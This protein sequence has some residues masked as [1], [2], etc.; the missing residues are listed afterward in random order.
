MKR[1]EWYFETKFG[2]PKKSR[3]ISSQLGVSFRLS[4]DNQRNLPI[5][6]C[7]PQAHRCPEGHKVG[8]PICP[9]LLVCCAQFSCLT[10]CE[11]DTQDDSAAY[12]NVY[13]DLWH[14]DGTTAL[15]VRS[16]YLSAES[17]K[18]AQAKVRLDSFETLR[19]A[20]TMQN[21]SYYYYYFKWLLFFTYAP[22]VDLR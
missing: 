10:I 22:Y 14:A 3:K 9:Q 6:P 4:L 7:F 2:N 8:Q 19:V 16:H 15:A 11:P 12:P 18:S 17:D 20:Y 13:A 1:T 5:L 21:K